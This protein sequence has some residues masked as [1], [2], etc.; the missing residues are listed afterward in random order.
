MI[1]HRLAGPLAR[2]LLPAL[3]GT[4]LTVLTGA[5]ARAADARALRVTGS[6]RLTERL[7]DLTM[8]TPALDFPV[9]VRILLPDGYD[10]RP[11]RRYPVLYL[12]HGSFDTAASWTDKG[13]AERL[14]AGLPLIV[15]MPATAGKGD[16]GGWASDWRNEGRGGP[17]KWE[18]FTIDQLVPWVDARYRTR[19]ERGGRAIAGLSMGGFSALSYA[20]RHPDLFAA[21]ASFSGAVDTNRLAVQPVV[22]LETL[23]D[24]GA[25]PDAIWGPAR[26][27]TASPCAG[28]A[29]GTSPRHR[30][31]S[32]V[33]RR[34]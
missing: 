26:T 8:D 1:V 9:Q 16:A 7:W 3:L 28:A 13:D 15:V 11:R 12:L 10:E 24:G 17:P 6:T 18:T 5:P 27:R 20:A 19:T 32:Q 33:P 14:T 2:L 30:A 21:A 25:T 31:T 23:A 4:L 22:Q 29:S 34:R